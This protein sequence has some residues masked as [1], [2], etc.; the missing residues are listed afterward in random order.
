MQA[1]QYVNLCMKMNIYLS[2]SYMKKFVTNPSP[3]F[4]NI[5]KKLSG[6]F[7]HGI[8][9]Y[10]MIEEGD[11]IAVALSGGKDSWTLLHLLLDLQASLP[12]K[13]EVIPITVETGFPGFN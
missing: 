4:K 9:T 10:K 2:I 3:E 12:I 7:K 8:T 6:K 11:R 5:Y 13:F 1:E